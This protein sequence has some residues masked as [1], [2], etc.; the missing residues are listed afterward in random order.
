MS[1]RPLRVRRLFTALAVIGAFVLAPRAGQGAAGTDEEKDWPSVILKLRQQLERTPGFAATRRQLA[2]AYNN[3]GVSLSNQGR[4]S[5]AIQQLGE[6]LR[7]DPGNLQV[8]TNLARVQLQAAQAAYQINQ[9][10]EA[11]EILDQVLALD[12]K[13]A[14]AYFLIGEIAY[15]NQRL[16]EAKA[17]WQQAMALN[18]SFE[19]AK[20]QLGRLEQELPI[21]S[22]FE[23]LSQFNFDLR[24]TNGL[25]RSAGYD[26][27][28][29]LLDAR[30]T[31]GSDFAYWP[32][33][34]TVVLVYSAQQFRQLRKEM[35]DWVAGQYDGKIRVPLPG[36]DL[37]RNTV[38]RTLR[39]EYTHALVH[40][41]T[42]DRLPTWFNEGLA[43]YE[44]WKGS[45]PQWLMLRQAV[46]NGTVI[47]WGNMS[48]Q[49]STTLA[50][51]TVL[52]A[53]EQS[54]NIVRY[55]VDRYGV[56][57]IRRILKAVDD[58]APLE[59]ALVREC[60]MKLGNL[61]R[62]WRKSLDDALR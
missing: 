56:W 3:Y 4:I 19:P 38:T 5:D 53:Y 44:G 35:P 21:E 11:R 25:D 41:L 29:A 50:A 12:P 8:R 27:R 57:R 17:A 34:K 16:K 7:L 20:E 1:R 51:P 32:K 23:R 54:H 62:D 39:H 15:H 55:L 9:F 48:A 42:H 59:E 61:E 10:Q 33:Q 30:R 36:V 14:E 24:Y 40:D 13:S 52:L 37:D 31:I 45:N 22:K 6:A 49:F 2:V 47:P 18:P 26:I 60:R 46:N 28:D 58:G 43:E